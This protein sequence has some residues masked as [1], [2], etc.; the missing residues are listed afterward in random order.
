[1]SGKTRRA[2]GAL[3]EGGLVFALLLLLAH[4]S[5][6]PKFLPERASHAMRCVSD[7][8]FGA[9]EN[10]EDIGIRLAWEYRDAE[11]RRTLRLFCERILNYFTRTAAYARALASHPSA[12]EFFRRPADMG[13]RARV[14]NFIQRAGLFRED[15]DEIIIGRAGDVYTRSEKRVVLPFPGEAI[16]AFIGFSGGHNKVAMFLLPG[17]RFLLLVPVKEQEYLAVI[18]NANMLRAFLNGYPQQGTIG[19]YLVCGDDRKNWISSNGEDGIVRRLRAGDAVLADYAK[20]GFI[21]FTEEQFRNI[22]LPVRFPASADDMIL[23]VLEE[24]PEAGW[25][26]LLVRDCLIFLIFVWMVYWIVRRLCCEVCIIW[27][28]KRHTRML[29]DRTLAESQDNFEKLI[30]SSRQLAR[31]AKLIKHQEKKGS[32]PVMDDAH[33]QS[34]LLISAEPDLAYLRRLISGA[35]K[36]ETQNVSG[37]DTKTGFSG[38]NGCA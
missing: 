31:Q 2:F 35:S 36:P 38:R 16:G 28:N 30:A 34:N 1:M 24:P 29:L 4:N 13:A 26:V 8:V 10:T 18:L 20:D 3:F 9:H 7:S 12:Q 25:Y 21:E 11:A 6:L 22:S 32:L 23:G 15:I 17:P 27:R 37:S 19:V 5:L 14:E 33:L